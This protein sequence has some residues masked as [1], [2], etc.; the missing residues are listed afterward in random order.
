MKRKKYILLYPFS[1]I[2]GTVTSIRNFLYNSEVLRG[3]EFRMPV[4]CVG[5]ITVGGTGKTPHCEYLIN[6]LKNNYHVALLSRGYKRKTSGFRIVTPDMSPSEAGDEPLQICRKFPEITV[7]VDRNR[8]RGVNSILKEYPDTEIIILDDGFQHRKII[9]GLS[10]ILTDFNRLMVR[11]HLLP[12]GE[13]REN[14][15]NM[16]RADLVLITK[17]PEN[18]SPMQRRL[19]VKEINKAPYQNLF[20][21]S[22]KYFSPAPL[23]PENAAKRSI[24]SECNREKNGIVLVT[25]IADPGPLREHVNRFADEIIHLDYPDHYTFTPGD[26]EKIDEAFSSL[27]SQEKF[28]ITTEKDSLRI[29]EFANIAEPLKASMWYIPLEIFF[30]NNDQNEFDNLISDYVRKNKRI[31]RLS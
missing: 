26:F 1:L 30:L 18:I 10:I 22:L 9:P 4:I 13:L 7:A 27:A 28:I 3:H 24:P 31:N 25:G 19:I 14:A 5:N 15:R 17:S 29:K 20:F 16:Y 21:T 2:Y 8:V 11:D 23:F 12:Y 6:L